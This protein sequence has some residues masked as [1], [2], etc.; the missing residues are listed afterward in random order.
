MLLHMI[1]SVERSKSSTKRHHG[2]HTVFEYSGNSGSRFQI[3]HRIIRESEILLYFVPFTSPFRFIHEF[4]P[5]HRSEYPA[6]R[7]LA[8]LICIILLLQY[9]GGRVFEVIDTHTCH[10]PLHYTCNINVHYDGAYEPTN[11][12]KLQTFF[13]SPGNLSFS[14]SLSCGFY[15]NV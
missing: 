1:H 7:I 11:D 5:A 2:N 15:N 14:L 4:G 9:R 6:N 3:V 12:K 8:P 13:P 10:A